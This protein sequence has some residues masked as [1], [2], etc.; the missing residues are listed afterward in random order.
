MTALAPLWLLLADAPVP[1]GAPPPAATIAAPSPSPVA[2]FHGAF[3]LSGMTFPSPVAGNTQDLYAVLTPLI[4]VDGGADFAFELG[5]DLRLLVVDDAT[6]QR[7]ADY[8]HVLRREDWNE[9]SDFGQILR[10]LRVGEDGGRWQLRAGAIDDYTLGW[11]HVINR[12]G[13]RLNPDYHPSGVRFVGFLGPTRTE[14][15]ASD[16]LG[17]RIFAAEEALDLGRLFGASADRFHLAGSAAYDFGR[18]GT[19]APP[20]GIA[21]LDADAALYRGPAL[22]LF[23]EAGSGARVDL[24][25]TALSAVLGVSAD[26]QLSVGRLSGKVELR[27]QQGTFRQGMFGAAYELARFSDVGTAGTPIATA[28]LPDGFS[29]YGEVA[30]QLGS[31]GSAGPAVTFSAAAEHYSWGRTDGDID[32]AVHLFSGRAIGS[33]KLIAVGL[34]QAP[35]Y[36]LMAELR[37]RFAASFY[38]LAYGG[39]AY[40]PQP[41]GTLLGGAYAGVGVAADFTR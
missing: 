27:K 10:S 3:E 26:A 32:A 21:N 5:A 15:F 30:T 16:F 9:A 34:G 12:Y 4:G 6:D 41:D 40:L 22:Q 37:W 8:G 29:G 39:K 17:G 35:R 7:S 1:T 11:G 28:E 33:A 25:S 23:L 18:A 13:D 14:V 2:H 38:A 31:D 20:I 19:V 36:S 24:K